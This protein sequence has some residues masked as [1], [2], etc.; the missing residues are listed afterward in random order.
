MLGVMV[1][2][3]AAA[4]WLAAL[5]SAADVA[6]AVAPA[7]SAPPPAPPPTGGTG[8]SVHASSLSSSSSSSSWLPWTP[9]VQRP[10]LVADSAT[11]AP[12]AYPVL[13]QLARVPPH[14]AAAAAAQWAEIM[15]AARGADGPIW[16]ALAPHR[17][18]LVRGSPLP[19]KGGR[20]RHVNHCV[21]VS[22]CVSL[23]GAWG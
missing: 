21:C 23:C 18:A 10:V 2:L 22:V 17:P 13:A 7:P 6:V 5:P 1:D 12:V 15:M 20:Q 16:P 3:P 19:M 4:A 9:R 14:A 11:V 8:A